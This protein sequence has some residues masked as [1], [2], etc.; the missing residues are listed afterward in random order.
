[1]LEASLVTSFGYGLVV[2]RQ[3]NISAF[4]IYF[5]ELKELND[6]DIPLMVAI[7]AKRDRSE[8][9]A[10]PPEA[11]ELAQAF[12]SGKKAVGL[13]E[14]GKNVGY[15]VFDPVRGWAR[16]SEGVDLCEIHVRKDLRGKGYG[17]AMLNDLVK[18]AKK[19]RKSAICPFVRQMNLEA[20]RF[21]SE[22]GFY[23]TGFLADFHGKGEHAVTMEKIV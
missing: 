2:E 1:V 10:K 4:K 5:V 7:T 13:M 11:D 12:A 19:S 22:N 17:T 9:A 21:Y 20:F 15:Y 6:K 18:R 23:V 3:I 14:S 8:N 16:G